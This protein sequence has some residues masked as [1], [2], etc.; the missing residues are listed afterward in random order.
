MNGGR[1]MSNDYI[2][3]DVCE[4]IGEVSV[5]IDEKPLIREMPEEGEFIGE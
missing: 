3:C 2:E 1:S 5:L 4:G